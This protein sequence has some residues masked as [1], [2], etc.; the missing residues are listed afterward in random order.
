[1]NVKRVD[2]YL[3]KVKFDEHN[4]RLEV[5]V[6]WAELFDVNGTTYIYHNGEFAEDNRFSS[7]S[8]RAVAKLLKDINKKIPGPKDD[9]Y[10]P[11]EELVSLLIKRLIV[12]EELAK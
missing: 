5:E 10:I 12:E 9:S 6:V 8:P 1:M 2:G 4:F 3:A 11:K 7:S